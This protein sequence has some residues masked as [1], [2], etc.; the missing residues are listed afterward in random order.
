VEGRLPECF[1]LKKVG[2]DEDIRVFGT[3]ENDFYSDYSESDEEATRH[4]VADHFVGDPVMFFTAL[5]D[6]FIQFEN[7]F[8]DDTSLSCD[9]TLF[10]TVADIER[11][12][13]EILDENETSFPKIPIR[14]TVNI[15]DDMCEEF[16]VELYKERKVAVPDGELK[17]ASFE[18]D[19]EPGTVN[20]LFTSGLFADIKTTPIDDFVWSLYDAEP[21]HQ[22]TLP[23]NPSWTT[24]PVCV[25]A[26][27]SLK[28][29]GYFT[30]D[31]YPIEG[32]VNFVDE[33]RLTLR[34]DDVP[35][36]I[37]DAQEHLNHYRTSS[38]SNININN[39]VDVCEIYGMNISNRYE[40]AEFIFGFSEL[41]DN[42]DDEDS[43]DSS[44]ESDSEEDLPS[45]YA[46]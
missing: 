3:S 29:L 41:L 25:Y 42:N 21:F 7:G 35:P 45:R 13:H 31:R 14:V 20:C 46:Y 1:S 39:I 40:V 22:E 36:K 24:N 15:N 8:R 23:D 12:L 30:Q 11:K 26:K 4:L 18:H 16:L 43:D 27:Q 34:N 10:R 38:A 37:M 32:S 6:A 5:F 2:T 33:G 17:W 28:T 44:E 19:G 9:T